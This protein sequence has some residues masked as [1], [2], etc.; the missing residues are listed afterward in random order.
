M[1]DAFRLAVKEDPEKFI[2]KITLF[3]DVSLRYT[4]ALVKGFQEAWQA[5]QTFDWKAILS[6]CQRYIEAHKDD[7]EEKSDDF[8]YPQTCRDFAEKAAR[9]ITIGSKDERRAF[10][11][12]EMIEQAN[13]MFETVFS[14]FA[15]FE[16]R[17]RK[18][19]GAIN[20]AINT[21]IGRVI[22]YFF[23]FSLH[24]KRVSLQHR[25]V[26][27]WGENK[28]NRFFEEID[29]DIDKGIYEGYI[30]F[31]R[32]LPN[33]CFLD[34]D[35]AHKKMKE[36]NGFDVTDQR[37]KN[38]MEG[39]LSGSA[40]YK[41]LYALLRTSYERAIKHKVFEDE[42]DQNLARHITLGYLRDY[43]VLNEGFNGTNISDEKGLFELLL[44]DAS[45]DE[46]R[47]RWN[48]VVD[49]MWS[50]TDKREPN[51]ELK[52]VPPEVIEKILAF[53]SWTYDKRNFVRK[54]LGAEGYG[55]FL[56]RICLL[57]LILPHVSD[58]KG[59]YKTK[60]WLMEC[61]PYIEKEYHSGFFIEYLLRFTGDDDLKNIA[62]IYKEMLKTATPIYKEGDIEDLMRRIKN[63][64]ENDFQEIV[65]TYG[66]R[67]QH[68]LRDVWEE[69]KKKEGKK[70]AK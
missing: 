23:L 21:P 19:R 20:Y 26:Q 62:E 65:E 39:Y 5:D 66:R 18:D 48:E 10:D 24:V 60:S 47:G 64:A 29:E 3:D 13:G 36:I 58:N 50:C 34:R 25:I 49:F 42:I 27:N 4:I 63:V 22:Q 15:P 54:Q 61:A 46:K 33:M 70:E 52:K 32:Y 12:D 1:A 41:D 40:V 69:W 44:Q 57:I 17:E 53:W 6:F 9:L 38:F 2:K 45:M 7:K 16:R 31:G 28:Y 14:A 56:S 68:F 35:W 43:E 59:K 51:E 55:L 67:G 11:T 30:F 37:W 8:D